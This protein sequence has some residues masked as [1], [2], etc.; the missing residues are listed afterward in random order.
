MAENNQRDLSIVIVNYNGQYWLKKLFLS[1]KKYFYKKTKFTVDYVVVD[2]ASTDNSIQLLKKEFPFVK[3]IALDKNMGFAAGNNVF[4]KDVS[5][6]Y[7]M[8]L[9]S[10]IEFSKKTSLDL[11]IKYLDHNPK[12]AC[13]TPKVILPDG[14]LD[15]ASH[16]GEPTPLASLFYF[17][18]LESLFPNSKYFSRYHLLYKKISTIHE[19]D[20]CSGAAMMVRTS[21]LQKI[22]LL[23]ERFF[24]Y[25]ED[26]DWCKRFREASYNIIFHPKV[27]ITHYKYKSGIKA[28]SRATSKKITKH[29]Y[30]TMLLYYDKYYLDKYPKILRFFLSSFIFIKKGGL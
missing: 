27:I 11:L 13:I 5:S 12:T 18:K 9:N 21:A 29:F 15:L 2:N 24:M 8:L 10:D 7:V 22:G 25:A 4:L 23:D 26:L 17:L 1:I 30:N 19:I 6:R 20:A 28:H 16:R 14:K 3:I